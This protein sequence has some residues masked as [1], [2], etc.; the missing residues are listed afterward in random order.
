MPLD[1]LVSSTLG[2]KLKHCSPVEST[3]ILGEKVFEDHSSS[4]PFLHSHLLDEFTLN[5]IL[6]AKVRFD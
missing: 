1:Q 2:I 4:L 5:T 3:P 6:Q